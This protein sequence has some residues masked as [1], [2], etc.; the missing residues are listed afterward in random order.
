[1]LC[2]RGKGESMVEMTLFE[3]DGEDQAHVMDWRGRKNMLVEYSKSWG[4]EIR[5]MVEMVLA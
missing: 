2:L 5:W 3:I 1:M 4:E